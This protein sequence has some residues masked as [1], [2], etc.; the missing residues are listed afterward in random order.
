MDVLV[1]IKRVPATGGRITLTDDDR[2][3]DTK[4][5]GFTVSPHE[6]C[7][8]EEAV[9]LIEQHGGASVVLTLGPPVA[10]EQLRDALALGIDRGV[11]LETEA[12][13]S[14]EATAE[15]IAIATVEQETPFDL[16]LFGNE[17]ADTADH[18]VGI[19]VAQALGM[20]CVT[21]VKSLEV[22][23]G[24]ATARREGADGTEVYELDLPAVITV[25]EGINV[26]RYPSIPGRIKAKK[27]EVAHMP[28][29]RPDETLEFL[30]LVML[31]ER[32]SEVK[33]LGT[34]PDTAPAVVDILLDLKLIVS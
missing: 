34:G 20:P 15:A 9:R 33:V 31:P 1:C 29:E 4:S 14:A 12:S 16:L 6:E 18:Q 22:V 21:G 30:K 28:V 13:W 11:L 5:L 27:K 3:I 32:P 19:R 7:A 24:R 17:A 10:E 26:P 25:R 8:V 23:D 2:A